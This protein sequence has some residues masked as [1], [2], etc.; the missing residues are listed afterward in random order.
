MS[1][2][3]GVASG[4]VLVGDAVGSAVGGSDAVVGD[5]VEAAATG[6]LAPGAA[7]MADGLGVVA[8]AD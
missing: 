8:S 4:G 7:V 5:C 3:V 6:A 1:V 2:S